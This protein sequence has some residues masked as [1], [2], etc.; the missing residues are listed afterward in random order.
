VAIGIVIDSLYSWQAGHL[1]REEAGRI[2]SCIESLGFQVDVAR[3][4]HLDSDAGIQ[5]VLQGLLDFQEH[6]G[7][8]LS[9]TL[10][11]GIGQPF[12]IHQFDEKLLFE[13]VSS[14]LRG[15]AQGLQ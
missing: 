1:S 5:M 4:F 6:L 12:E 2:R 8:E 9:I 10:L 15:S 3:R 11:Q 14:V 7:G 13:C